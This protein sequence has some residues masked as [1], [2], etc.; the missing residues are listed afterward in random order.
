MFAGHRTAVITAIKPKT[1]CQQTGPCRN[2][3]RFIR[4]GHGSQQDSI[5]PIGPIGD[6]VHAVVDAI[7]DI[8]IKTP[9]RSKQGFILGRPP[10]KTVTSRVVL[11]VRL[12]FHDYAPKQTSIGLAF[13]QPAAH[14]IRSHDLCWAAEEGVGQGWKVLANKRG[15]CGRDQEFSLTFVQSA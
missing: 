13:H 5:G 7:A 12:R 14:Q 11:G 4:Q 10:S 2:P 1:T 15:V 3:L 9:W 6:H 8:H